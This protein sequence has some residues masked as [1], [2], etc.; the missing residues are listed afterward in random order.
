MVFHWSVGLLKFPELSLAVSAQFIHLNDRL[1]I[2]SDIHMNFENVVFWPYS[3]EQE[4]RI[5]GVFFIR[6]TATIGRNTTYT[7]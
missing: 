7:G 4:P 5:S 6:G 1:C 3:E 2:I